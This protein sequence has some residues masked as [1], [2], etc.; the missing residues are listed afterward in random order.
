MRQLEKSATT[1]IERALSHLGNGMSGAIH[2]SAASQT[3]RQRRSRFF[4]DV[5][6]TATFTHL[7]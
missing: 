7:A 1:A 3:G 2:V 5:P 4:D 6:P